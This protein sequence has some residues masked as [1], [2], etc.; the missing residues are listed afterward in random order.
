M[1]KKQGWVPGQF[2]F[3]TDSLPKEI[4]MRLRA[5]K[6]HHKISQRDVVSLGI[7]AVCVLGLGGT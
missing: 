7:M 3:V 2:K 4:Y 6:E 5:L 1:E